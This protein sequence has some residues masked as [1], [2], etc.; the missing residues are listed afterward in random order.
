MHTNSAVLFG[1]IFLIASSCTENTSLP[2]PAQNK[3]VY[4][5][6][7]E[8]DDEKFF[9]IEE[10]LRG[11]DVAMIEAGYRYQ[12]LYWAGIDQNWEYASYQ[13]SKIQKAIELAGIRRSARKTSAADFLN[14]AIPQMELAIEPKDSVIFVSEFENFTQSCNTCHAKENVP[15]FTVK[16]PLERQSPI[17]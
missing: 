6:L 9:Q 3:K 13:L 11:F 1:L 15:F 5:W 14:R 7:A 4:K 2:D 12:E 10:Q 8:D 16:L 17:R